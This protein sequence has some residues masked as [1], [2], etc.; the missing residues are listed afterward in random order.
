M[1]LAAISEQ[2]EMEIDTHGGSKLARVG[3]K[4]EVR[5]GLDLLAPVPIGECPRVQLRIEVEFESRTLRIGI[6]VTAAS[7]SGSLPRR[8]SCQLGPGVFCHLC[9]LGYRPHL[10][11]T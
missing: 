3:G 6:K 10:A 5:M 1:T 2:I 11:Q 9:Q 7:S 4:L 8:R